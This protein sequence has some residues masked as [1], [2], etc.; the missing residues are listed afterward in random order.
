MKSVWSKIEKP[1][2]YLVEFNGEKRLVTIP[3]NEEVA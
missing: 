3:E 2:F 1:V